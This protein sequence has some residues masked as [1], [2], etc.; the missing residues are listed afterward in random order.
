MLWESGPSL[1][2]R[3]A[4]LRLSPL[5]LSTPLTYP[6]ASWLVDLLP[7]LT[8]PLFSSLELELMVCFRSLASWLLL[9]K[10]RLPAL[11]LEVLSCSLCLLLGL[12]SLEA[13]SVVCFSP[14]ASL[15]GL[16]S[17]GVGGMI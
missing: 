16:P 12:C 15:S 6:A 7:A 9:Q 11:L 14:G 4:Y 17:P 5:L 1:L 13:P 8:G 3:L 2:S 10:A